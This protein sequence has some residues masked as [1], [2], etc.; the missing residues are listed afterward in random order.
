MSNYVI[1]RSDPANGSFLVQSDQIDGTT[2][3][4]S[5]GLYV[6]P[7]SGLTALSSNSS[8]VLAGRGI[9]D[10]GELVQNDL[11]Y[12]MEHFAY[13]S[14]PLTPVQGQIW[15][16][17]ANYT[18]P[19]FPSD[20]TVAGLFV[21]SGTAWTPVLAANIFGN[22]DLGGA[23]I[24]SLGNA[25]S[26]TDA[27]NRNTADGRYLQLAGGTL[28]GGVAFTAGATTFTGG[29]VVYNAG[30]AVSV[31]DTP[32][33]ALH[34]ANKSY[35]DARD[36]VVTG[37]VNAEAIT[38]GNADTVLTGD[39]ATINSQLPNF[40]VTTGDT[41]TGNL[42]FSSTGSI[43]FVGGG[44]S[45]INLGLVR[46]QQLGAPSLN[47]DATTKLYVDTAIL[48]AI[49]GLP[50]SAVSDGVVY[51]GVFTSS[52]G[53]LTLQRTL[54]LP[55]VTVTGTMAPF[56][57]GHTTGAITYDLASPLYSRSVLIISEVATGGYPVIPTS[58]AIR[59]LDQTLIGLTQRIER[60]IV[61]GDGTT[62]SFNLSAFMGY[63]VSENRLSISMDGVK[64]Y[65]CERGMSRITFTDTPISPKS[66][67]GIPN[68]VYAFNITVD[69]TLYSSVTIVVGASYTYLQMVASLT[70]AFTTLTIPAT[71]NLDQRYD[72]MD[73][74]IQSNTSGNGSNVTISYGVGTYFQSMPTSSAPVN[75]SITTDLAYK[76]TGVSSITS[77]NVVFFTA[78]PV[79]SVLEFLLLPL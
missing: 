42:A 39:I 63:Q 11:V 16:K 14:R 31:T 69:G 25:V 3:P 24:T 62:T 76:E 20:P 2:R 68:G 18:D 12:L 59:S 65:C 30:V 48:T 77:T 49:A 58:N 50:P 6:N 19:S 54:G 21:Y 45:S 70:S 41:M 8:L 52:T 23:L 5:A 29:T 75:T 71:V 57:H 78:P 9:T 33:S 55:D 74:I 26:G 37:L 7:V 67:I 79:G 4:W 44:S 66:V 28:T 17:N 60:Q 61:I 22:V 64:Q 43:T 73:L 40:I 53:V 27:L 10:Y 56:N 46:I 51:G 47:N 35:V 1:K 34:V 13:K 32:S 72:T 15:Y 38:R 36:A